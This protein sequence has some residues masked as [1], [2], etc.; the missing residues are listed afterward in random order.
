MAGEIPDPRPG[1]RRRVSH[2]NDP[3]VADHDGR[4]AG[5]AA[6]RRVHRRADE[7]RGQNRKHRWHRNT[8]PLA[9]SLGQCFVDEDGNY[10][11]APVQTEFGWHVILREGSRDSE[12]PP[13]ESVRETIVAALQQKRFQSYLESIRENAE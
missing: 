11:T 10:T 6:R 5:L 12:P 2:G 13:L 7:R 8:T 4:R 3:P 9:C 1:R